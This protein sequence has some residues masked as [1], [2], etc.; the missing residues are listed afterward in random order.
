LPSLSLSPE[1]KSKGRIRGKN[2]PGSAVPLANKTVIFGHAAPV[3]FVPFTFPFFNTS[4]LTTT[5][6]ASSK[7]PF[8]TDVTFI[9]LFRH[10]SS[11][12]E[13]ENENACENGSKMARRRNTGPRITA[14]TGRKERRQGKKEIKKSK[15]CQDQLFAKR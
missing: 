12:F 5:A 14:S 13:Q 7:N 15:Y 10:P 9:K 3:P 8:S 2:T 11:C 6:F 4:F 1:G